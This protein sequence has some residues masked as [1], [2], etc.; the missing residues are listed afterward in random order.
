MASEKY[1]KK[2]QQKALASSIHKKF[3]PHVKRTAFEKLKH[4]FRCRRRL[5]INIL[6]KKF[7]FQ[8]SFSYRRSVDCLEFFVTL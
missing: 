5:E 7:F 8:L 3:V 4:L 1:I 2:I 6:L